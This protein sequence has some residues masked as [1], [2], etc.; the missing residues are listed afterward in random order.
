[1][2]DADFSVEQIDAIIDRDV[3]GAVQNIMNHLGALTP[4]NVGRYFYLFAKLSEC[5]GNAF[6][7][8]I[9]D[10]ADLPDSQSHEAWIEE[11][12]FSLDLNS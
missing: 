10:L 2:A 12:M 3:V 6:S 7:P 5:W 4:D 8:L 1:M 9:G 11:E